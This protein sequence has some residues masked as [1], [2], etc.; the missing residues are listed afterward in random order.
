MDLLNFES[1]NLKPIEISNNKNG[2]V[3]ND[4]GVGVIIF[5]KEVLT[6]CNP[7][8]I[9]IKETTI[10]VIYSIRPCPKGCSASAGLFAIL[11]PMIVIIEEAASDKL[12]NASAK[13]E[14]ELESNPTDNLIK[15]SNELVII[16]I[17]PARLA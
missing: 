5:W 8:S 11:N 4:T 12:L 10:A 15:K 13:I 3:S 9:T 7:T 16:P 14:T 17:I 1:H 2:I 6:N